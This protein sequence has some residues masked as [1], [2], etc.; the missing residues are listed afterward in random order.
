M[1]SCQVLGS[2]EISAASAFFQHYVEFWIRAVNKLPEV[3]P[4]F[5]GFLMET[6]QVGGTIYQPV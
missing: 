3:F 5:R 2:Y 4:D 1:I 6:L